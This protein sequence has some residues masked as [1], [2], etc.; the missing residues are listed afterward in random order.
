MTFRIASLAAALVLAS[1]FVGT[2]E[3]QGA[4]MHLG[5]RLSYQFD[6]EEI[7]V[8]AQFSTPLA[9]HLEFYPSFDYFFVDPGSF[10]QLNA[11]LKYSV[12]SREL[13]WLYLG[14][15][16]NISRRGARG[17]HDTQAGLNLFAG[18]ESRRGRIHPFGEFRVTVGDGSTAQI[19]AGVNF[20]LSGN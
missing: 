2:A 13:H 19:A 7:G 4:R 3:A 14:S 17:A 18:A 1:V 9:R 20:T 12:P 8:G 15:G 6:L 5:P 10:W 16:L 11:D